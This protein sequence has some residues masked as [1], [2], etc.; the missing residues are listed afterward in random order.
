MLNFIST[1]NNTTNNTTT[2]NTTTN[3]NNNT[4]SIP[5]T[6]YTPPA[7]MESSTV[8]TFKKYEILYDYVRNISIKDK[9]KIFA[10]MRTASIELTADTLF[11]LYGLVA[12]EF[13]TFAV[14]TENSRS[15]KE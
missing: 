12:G 15:K 8:A 11:P 4:I 10:D 2:N 7:P 13:A 6:M 1:L 5:I 14:L 3:T 9:R